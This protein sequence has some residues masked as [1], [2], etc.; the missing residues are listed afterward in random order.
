MEQQ[1]FT[2]DITGGDFQE[3]GVENGANA[4]TEQQPS[5]VPAE[6][7]EDDMQDSGAADAPGRDDDR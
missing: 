1:D 5:E 3:N 6:P 4:E 7:T 2:E